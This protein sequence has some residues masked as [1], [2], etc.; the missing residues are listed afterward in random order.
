LVIRSPQSPAKS[1]RA[2]DELA[3]RL[4]QLLVK[5]GLI[6]HAGEVILVAHAERK[7]GPVQ[8]ALLD[9]VG[10]LAR[11]AATKAT[12]ASL[13]VL[14]LCGALSPSASYVG[15]EGRPR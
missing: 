1:G 2:S 13:A 12:A 14:V 8:K 11:L 10:N 7:A 4:G 15:G 9:Y 6:E 5:H 3:L